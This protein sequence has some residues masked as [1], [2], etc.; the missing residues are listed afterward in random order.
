MSY[1][2]RDLLGIESLSE[3]SGSISISSNTLT[4]DLSSGATVFYVSLN[5]NINTFSV[6][7]VPASV[8]SF[9]LILTA[10]G[11]PRSITWGGSVKWPGA[12]PP[13]LTSTNNKVDILSFVSMDG[14]STWYGFV[15]GQ[16]F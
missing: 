10:D 14:G 13:T 9:T 15:G 6:T 7:N 1:W 8:S 12:T 2:S 3:V 11:T 4:V 5:A 16:N